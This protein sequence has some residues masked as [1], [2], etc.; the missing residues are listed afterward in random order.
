[1]NPI[2]SIS[3]WVSLP[4]EVRYKI[5]SLFSIPRSSN[6]VVSDGHIET[7][8]TTTEDFKHLTI[9]KMQEYLDQDIT[10]FHKLFDMV[11][12]KVTDDIEGRKPTETI[13][14]SSDSPMTV[15][16]EPKKRGRKAKA[17]A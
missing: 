13:M 9:A 4:T 3:M 15:I 12:A 10:D 6:T 11:V 14:A 2:L 8:G 1:M 5:R 7:D 16:I 17:H